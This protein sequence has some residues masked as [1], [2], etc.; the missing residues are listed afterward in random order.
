MFAIN[1]LDIDSE[2]QVG[3]LT[4]LQSFQSQFW[5]FFFALVDLWKV[6]NAFLF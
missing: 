3:E 4:L 1:R 2:G 6:E 5:H